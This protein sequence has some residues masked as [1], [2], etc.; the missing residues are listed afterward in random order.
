MRWLALV[1]ALCACKEPEPP[2]RP[3]GP[4]KLSWLSDEAAA[5]EKARAEHKGVV[6]NLVATWSQPSLEVAHLL[7]RPRIAA[8]IKPKFVALLIDVSN[9]TDRDEALQK[10]YDIP[11]VPALVFL[12]ADGSVLHQLVHLPSESEL[13]TVIDDAAAKLE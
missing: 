9:G 5:F 6:M 2:D 4:K 7:E 3:P 8:A 10:R 12:T 1:I 13:R 11:T